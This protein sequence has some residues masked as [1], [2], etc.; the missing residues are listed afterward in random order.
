MSE[1][2]MVVALNATGKYNVERKFHPGLYPDK[3]EI[4]MMERGTKVKELFPSTHGRGYPAQ[5]GR[6]YPEQHNW[7]YGRGRRGGF[8]PPNE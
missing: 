7:N 4:D 5:F 8:S 6:G 3:D 2:E 1:A